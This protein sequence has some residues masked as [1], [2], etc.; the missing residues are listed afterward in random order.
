MQLFKL[1]AE[2]SVATICSLFR[3]NLTTSLN[4]VKT[5][6]EKNKNR[7]RIRDGNFLIFTP[8]YFAARRTD[9]RL[10]RTR[11][12]TMVKPVPKVLFFCFFFLFFYI[13]EPRF[14]KSSSERAD[15]L[16]WK[17]DGKFLTR[18][19]MKFFFFLNRP[20]VVQKAIVWR[21][22]G[23][24]W[25]W[26]EKDKFFSED[27]GKDKEKMAIAPEIFLM[28]QL[29]FDLTWNH[30]EKLSFIKLTE[31]LT[32]VDFSILSP[33]YLKWLLRS[34]LSPQMSADHADEFFTG[35]KLSRKIWKTYCDYRG[36]FRHDVFPKTSTY[37]NFL[38]K[39]NFSKFFFFLVLGAHFWFTRWFAVLPVVQR[40]RQKERKS[41]SRMFSGL[42]LPLSSVVI[43]ILH[44]GTNSNVPFPSCAVRS[45]SEK[46]LTNVFKLFKGN[47][48]TITVFAF[49]SKA[50][51]HFCLLFRLRIRYFRENF[52]S[53]IHA[54]CTRRKSK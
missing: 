9:E 3:S 52:E 44:R 23:W 36:N 45:L 19:K 27:H 13:F 54:C 53:E 37:D 31:I 6:T 34:N 42:N 22:G 16:R 28:T 41:V 11:R 47:V 24:W 12:G 18:R 35:S 17:I 30:R 50:S 14:G 10:I 29:K 38:F 26:W 33:P 51:S 8:A 48:Q 20:S 15:F 7:K 21:G 39:S 1:K 5:S 4:V 46:L 32:A 49:P 2:F 25:W 40:R 43:R